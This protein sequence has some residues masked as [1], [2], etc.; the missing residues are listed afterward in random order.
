MTK[1]PTDSFKKGSDTFRTMNCPKYPKPFLRCYAIL[2]MQ[3]IYTEKKKTLLRQ[4]AKTL[5][6]DI[7]LLEND[8][9]PSGKHGMSMQKNAVETSQGTLPPDC[10][11]LRVFGFLT[12]STFP[13][14]FKLREDFMMAAILE[15]AICLRCRQS[16]G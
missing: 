16:G 10:K 12:F 5:K 6:A 1:C 4:P 13:A 11:Q 3:I 7:S 8:L 9:E 14:G 15:G 2:S